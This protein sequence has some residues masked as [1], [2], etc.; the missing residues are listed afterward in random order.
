MTKRAVYFSIGKFSVIMRELSLVGF[1]YRD[2]H[3]EEKRA[4]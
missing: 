2:I 4:D 1:W 3:K